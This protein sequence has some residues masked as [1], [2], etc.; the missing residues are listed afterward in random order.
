[1]DSSF[2]IVV[3]LIISPCGVLNLTIIGFVLRA[4]TA[5]LEGMQ[6]LVRAFDADRSQLYL[7]V[8][9][10]VRHF[11]PLPEALRAPQFAN[12]AAY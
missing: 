5:T 11:S 3:K 6:E 4:G 12:L 7:Q 9:E 10:H 8:A 1:V 2:Q